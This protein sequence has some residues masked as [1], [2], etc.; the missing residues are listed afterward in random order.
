[1][2]LNASDKRYTNHTYTISLVVS[3]TIVRHVDIH[4]DCKQ[5]ALDILADSKHSYMIEA[6]SDYLLDKDYFE[7]CVF[8]GNEGKPCQIDDICIRCIR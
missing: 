2:A 7:S 5:D 8:L 1:M 3:N 6:D 4:A